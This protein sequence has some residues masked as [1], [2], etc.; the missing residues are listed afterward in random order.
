MRFSTEVS[1]FKENLTGVSKESKE[2]AL[3]F[4]K[5]IE[6]RGGT[7]INSALS[8]A[9]SFKSEDARPYMI[10]FLTDGHP[11]IGITSQN[12]IIKNIKGAN[13]YQSRIFT[14]GLGND[15]NTHLLDQIARDTRAA[16]QYVGET[17]NIE[18]KVSSF[19]DKVSSPVLSD[20]KLDFGT[21]K[22]DEIYPR[23][24]PDLFKGQPLIIMGR[25][26]KGGHTAL[27]LKGKFQGKEKTMSYDVSFADKS[28]EYPFI[29]GLWAKRKVGFLL[30][31][32]RLNGHNQELVN[33]VKRLG[34]EYGIV[35]P[36]TSYLVV[37]DVKP[38]SQPRLVPEAR[39]RFEK[40]KEALRDMGAVDKDVEEDAL[41]DEKSDFEAY[42]AKAPSINLI[43]SA[44]LILDSGFANL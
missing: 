43:I 24:L 16:N 4:I 27:T 5:G 41:A 44:M 20:L 10:V 9:L 25:Y 39:E 34:M 21:V 1:N 31:N 17:E 23:H 7:D 11:T 38:G 13:K 12:E 19:F 26:E 3:V 15:L 2:D 29:A 33:E 40:K 32:I 42:G 6:A 18:V 14:F 35:T 37:E 22:V 8:Q 28:D 36:Y 30:E